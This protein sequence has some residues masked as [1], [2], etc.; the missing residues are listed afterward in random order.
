MA[1]EKDKKKEADKG[2][3]EE[4]PAAPAAAAPAK[5]KKGLLI[6]G[7]IALL[8]VLI[9]VPVAIFS[10]KSKAPEGS[11]L[12][13]DAA[14]D[15][16]KLSVEGSH[17]EEEIAE[18]EEAIGA[19]FPMENFVV[20]LSGGHYIRAQVQIE[21][22]EKDVPKRFFARIVPM[23]DSIITMLGSRT[24]EDLLSDK[25]KEA[26]KNDIKDMVNELLKKEVVK[27][28]YFTQFFIQ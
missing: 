24:Q 26:V 27:Q 9:C 6:G 19:F 7:G 11:E 20:N 5:S 22:T 12:S 2:G 4:A 3:K 15:E 17:D 1:D 14:Q 28:V 10:M 8:L 18:G 23:R 21:F 13:A 25:G 16:P